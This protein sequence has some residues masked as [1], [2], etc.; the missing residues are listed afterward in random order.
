MEQRKYR[1]TRRWQNV[2]LFLTCT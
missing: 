2:S 1:S